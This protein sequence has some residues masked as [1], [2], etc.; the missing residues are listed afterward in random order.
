M[1]IPKLNE[2]TGLV[3]APSEPYEILVTRFHHGG[4]GGSV[5]DIDQQNRWFLDVALRGLS[6]VPSDLADA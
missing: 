1:L 6:G 3:K 2:G 5:I 4:S